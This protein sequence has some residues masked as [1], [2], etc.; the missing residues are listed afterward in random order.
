MLSKIPKAI[1]S[2]LD[3]FGFYANWSG[4]PLWKILPHLQ[5]TQPTR[6]AAIT[7][8][9]VVAISHQIEVYRVEDHN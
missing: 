7:L 6:S 8:D 4:N 3:W 9:I 1:R 5:P 2:E